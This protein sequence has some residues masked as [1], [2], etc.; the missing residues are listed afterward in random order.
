MRYLEKQRNCYLLVL[1]VFLN[2]G[3]VGTAAQD[4][5]CVYHNMKYME[6][7]WGRSAKLPA[8]SVQ[9]LYFWY[10]L[11]H[12]LGLEQKFYWP[13]STEILFRYLL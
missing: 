3:A 9:N 10:V 6:C 1:F 5:V 7:S 8:N 12:N 11:C 4:F 13:D 2:V